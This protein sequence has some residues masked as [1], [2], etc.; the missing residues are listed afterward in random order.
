MARRE[1]SPKQKKSRLRAVKG[2]I[3]RTSRKVV[4]RVKTTKRRAE[5]EAPKK[6]RSIRRDSDIPLEVLD[7]AYIP[8]QTSLKASFRVNGDDR[9]RDQEFAGGYSDERWN[10]E[11]RFTNKSGDPRIGTHRR[12]YEPGE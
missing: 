1:K 3:T 4:A 2:A 12:K 9:E 7:R 11:D 6:P 5:P 8:K 10:D